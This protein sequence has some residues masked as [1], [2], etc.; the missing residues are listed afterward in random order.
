MTARLSE[1]ER[2]SE[3]KEVFTAFDQDNDGRIS[4]DELQESI[5]SVLDE[6]IEDIYDLLGI[7][8]G[9]SPSQRMIT[10]EQFK[11]LMNSSKVGK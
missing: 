10:L 11:T 5:E 7:P 1:E 6:E 2:D 8:K 4:V 3:L 9:G